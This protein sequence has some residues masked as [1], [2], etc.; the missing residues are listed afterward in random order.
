MKKVRFLALGLALVLALALTGCKG[1]KPLPEGMD[2]EKTGE[3]GRQLATMLTEGDYQGVL[4]QFDPDML[5]QY[6]ITA[7]DL[8]EL[9][10]STEE[11]GAFKE[12]TDTVCVGTEAKEFEGTFASVTVYC[13]HEDGDVIYVFSLDTDLSLLGLQLKTK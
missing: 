5:S 13:E 4:D 11:C 9:M 7:D 8:G 2:L 3:A 10:A 6:Q 12:I 1:S